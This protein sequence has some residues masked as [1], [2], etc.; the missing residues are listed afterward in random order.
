MPHAHNANNR[1][2]PAVTQRAYQSYLTQYQAQTLGDPT[3]TLNSSSVK[4]SRQIKHIGSNPLLLRLRPR[5]SAFPASA[6]LPTSGSPVSTSPAA[7]VLP[8]PPQPLSPRNCPRL[9]TMPA[10]VLPVLLL[11]LCSRAAFSAGPLVVPPAA[12]AAEENSGAGMISDCSGEPLKA[13][14]EAAGMESPLGLT[15]PKSDR[16]PRAAAAA[17]SPAADTTE[18]WPVSTS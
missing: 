1:H 14:A 10:P 9:A 12:E 5:R 6:C 8:L 16:E 7:S 18:L 2:N 3:L 4:V 13:A 11:L 17:S 15:A